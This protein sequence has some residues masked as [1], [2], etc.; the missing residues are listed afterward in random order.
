MKPESAYPS[1]PA[2]KDSGIEWLGII[3]NHWSIKLIKRTT[4]LKGRVGWKGLTSDEYLED[5]Y[6][7]LVTGTDFVSK[8]V[9]WSA[10]YCVDKER[11]EDDPYIQLR[12]GDLLVTKDGTIGKLALVANLQ[13]PACLNSGIF[14]VRPLDSYITAY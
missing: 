4:Y 3:P 7:H 13:K 2:Y 8:F 1:Y 12:D 9:N 11:Y 5:G 10:C 14:L 6:A